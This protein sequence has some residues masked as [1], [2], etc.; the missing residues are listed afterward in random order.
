MI[1]KASK[2]LQKEWQAYELRML[3][4][5]HGRS[6]SP[7][8]EYQRPFTKAY[9]STSSKRGRDPIPSAS[10]LGVSGVVALESADEAFPSI[11]NDASFDFEPM[12]RI[13]FHNFFSVLGFKDSSVVD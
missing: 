8:A 3:D 12:V 6:K 7:R 11:E 9:T 13:S 2:L 5:A 4:R 1:D 10:R